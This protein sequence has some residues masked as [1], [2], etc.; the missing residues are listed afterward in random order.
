MCYKIKTKKIMK[1][2]FERYLIYYLVVV[3]ILVGVA[4]CWFAY[5]PTVGTELSEKNVDWGNFGSFFW[6]FGTMC[7]SMLNVIIF[8]IIS[9]RLYKKQIFDTYRD[10][11][12]RLI[13]NLTDKKALSLNMINLI[14]FLA[15]IYKEATFN[16]EVRD[17]A[18]YLMAECSAY[19]KAPSEIALPDLLGDLTAFQISLLINE[20]HQK[21]NQDQ[22]NTDGQ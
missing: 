10:A 9:Q 20:Y 6:G 4:V 5:R 22:S 17:R 7:F 16:K 14:S 13:R 1:Q 21:E 12:D 15:G 2:H 19:L 3:I 11:L 8:Y 18:V